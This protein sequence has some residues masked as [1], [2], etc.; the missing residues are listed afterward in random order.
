M[1][2]IAPLSLEATDLTLLRSVFGFI[3]SSPDSIL[4]QSCKTSASS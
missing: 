3:S 1:P 4:S 2:R